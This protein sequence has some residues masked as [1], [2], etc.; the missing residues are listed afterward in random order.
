MQGPP[1]TNIHPLYLTNTKPP[2]P[3][4]NSP[5][6]TSNNSSPL[7]L[8]ILFLTPHTSSQP[9]T[10][11]S[12]PR[13]ETWA[14]GSNRHPSTLAPLRF[15]LYTIRGQPPLHAKSPYRLQ[16]GFRATRWRRY[17]ILTFIAHAFYILRPRCFLFGIARPSF[18][19]ASPP[20]PP[21]PAGT[22]NKETVTDKERPLIDAKAA[23]VSLGLPSNN[24]FR[25]RTTS[26]VA[27]GQ[28][29]P[30]EP[31][32]RPLSRNPFLDDAGTVKESLQRLPS[33][34]AKPAPLTGSAAE[35][36]VRILRLL[37]PRS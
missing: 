15:Q 4:H 20:T 12:H 26:P 24:P 27:S 29:S 28:L 7:R 6:S 18:W 3:L 32:P 14:C 19:A 17:A 35:L 8:G 5:Y 25:N 13:I 10:L 22:M 1:E 16:H 36:F 21:S 34:A 11:I 9:I 30:M 2:Q 37:L 31:P 23:G 33:P